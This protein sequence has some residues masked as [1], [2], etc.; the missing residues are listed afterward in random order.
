M[1]KTKSKVEVSSMNPPCCKITAWFCFK[2]P[3]LTKEAKIVG[4]NKL[5]PT[6]KIVKITI[7]ANNARYL[8]T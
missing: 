8:R 7:P 3:L 6:C 2:I 5:E 1:D 4:D